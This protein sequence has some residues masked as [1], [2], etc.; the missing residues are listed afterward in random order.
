M[1]ANAIAKYLKENGLKQSD[2]CS[3][4]G[5]SKACIQRSLYGKRPLS[6]DEYEKICVALHV[7]YEYFF[8]KRH[9][10]A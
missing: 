2:L 10:S 7:P 1:I 3:K 9:E 8:E 6:I 4:T 5:L